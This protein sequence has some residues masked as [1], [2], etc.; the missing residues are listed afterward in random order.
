MDE[1]HSKN[2]LNFGSRNFGLSVEIEM[3]NLMGYAWHIYGPPKLKAHVLY[4]N[5]FIGVR[6]L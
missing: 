4:I 3:D 6:W 1:F 5:P 2:C